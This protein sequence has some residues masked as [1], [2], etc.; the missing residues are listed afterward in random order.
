MMN[1]RQRAKH[2]PFLEFVNWHFSHLPPLTNFRQ[3]SY[4]HF[5]QLSFPI[6]L[7]CS[8]W[9]TERVANFERDTL[10]VKPNKVDPNSDKEFFVKGRK[11]RKLWLMQGS[12][13]FFFLQLYDRNIILRNANRLNVYTAQRMLRLGFCFSLTVFFRWSE[14]PI[15]AALRYRCP[16]LQIGSETVILP[17]SFAPCL[18]PSFAQRT[19]CFDCVNASSRFLYLALHPFPRMEI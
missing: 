2:T 16:T 5:C 1:F 15:N 6:S 18:T 3:K 14:T 8:K 19:V 11:W 12:R 4:L 17:S 13:K 10:K 7:F 9:E